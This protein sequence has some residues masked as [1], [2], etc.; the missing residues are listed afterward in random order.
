MRKKYSVFKEKFPHI[1]LML[2]QGYPYGD[3]ILDLNQHHELNLTFNT[4]RSYLYRYRK[5]LHSDIN[6]TQK[7]KEIKSDSLAV[8]SVEL[9]KEEQTLTTKSYAESGAEFIAKFLNNP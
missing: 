8:E 2:D 9:E 7:S 5:E 3:V 6:S 4:F 1:Q